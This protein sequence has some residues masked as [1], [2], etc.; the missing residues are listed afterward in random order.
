M[1]ATVTAYDALILGDAAAALLET[2]IYA[3]IQSHLRDEAFRL[4]VD[5]PFGELGDANRA[6]SRDLMATSTTL[7]NVLRRFIDDGK[8]ARMRLGR[9]D[10]DASVV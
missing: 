7:Q 10:R 1:T 3:A 9:G 6:V 8:D 5:A 4:F 2:P